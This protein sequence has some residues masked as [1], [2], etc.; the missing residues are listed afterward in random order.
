MKNWKYK[1]WPSNADGP[2]PRTTSGDTGASPTV[3]APQS[4]KERVAAQSMPQMM[5]E[6]ESPAVSP[7][8]SNT[9]ASASGSDE[10]G[11]ESQSS[12]DEGDD[13]PV[14]DAD[15]GDATFHTS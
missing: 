6:S 5:V 15:T 7:P 10:S 11:W 8:S 13:R 1:S 4:I 2:S 14:L 9:S 3:N 12:E